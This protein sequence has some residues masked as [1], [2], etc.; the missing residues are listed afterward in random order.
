M[1]TFYSI[2]EREKNEEVQTKAIKV[3]EFAPVISIEKPKNVLYIFN[4]EV[5][6]LRNMAIIIGSITV[7]ASV[8]DPATSGIEK[9]TI[10]IDGNALVTFEHNIEYTIDTTLL[11]YRYCPNLR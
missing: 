2:D 10:Y 6:P 1:I 8:D 9:A 4:K 5:I 3:D 11:G 7:K